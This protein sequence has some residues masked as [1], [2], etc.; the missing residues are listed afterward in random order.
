[1]KLKIIIASICIAITLVTTMV[2]SSINQ[3]KSKQED[4]ATQNDFIA[5]N[6]LQEN[7]LENKQ[8]SIQ[9]STSN[10]IADVNEENQIKSDNSATESNS[11]TTKSDALKV[12]DKSEI[13][14]QV[15]NNSNASQ[16]NVK[17][18]TKIEQKQEEPKVQETETKTEEKTPTTPTKSDL[19]YWCAEGGKHHVT[20]D[21]ANEHGYYDTWDDAHTAFENY[22]KGWAFVQYKISQCA[23]GKFYFWA[24]Q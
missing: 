4:I 14:E 6:N 21:G 24:I 22:T 18:E 11:R 3:N 2:L 17:K 12:Q 7:L 15:K 13:K 10:N 23:C 8:E 20:G 5:E 19:S 16:I 9:E 1:M